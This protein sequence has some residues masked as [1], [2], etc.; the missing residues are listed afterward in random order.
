MASK[1][2]DALRGSIGFYATMAFCLLAIAVSGYFLLSDR[3]PRP[4]QEFYEDVPQTETT[5][6][7]VSPTGA[8][9]IPPV[10]EEPPAAEL[11]PEPEP[12]PESKPVSAP[13]PIPDTTPVEAE[14]PRLVVSPLKG[15]V[16]AAFSVDDLI[17]S[18]TMEDWRT[19]DGVDIAAA[20]G[21][22]VMAASAGT[23][24]AVFNDSMMGTTVVLEHS[25]GYQTTYANLQPVPT[26]KA[27]D[28]VSAGQIIGAVGTTAPAEHAQQ[29]H[30]H[31]A[32]TKDGA[33]VNPDE[34]LKN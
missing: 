16:L 33:V 31:F 7:E 4:P 28:S 12:I 5:M 26:V 13:T 21:T 34:F 17:Y 9:D 30:L 6:P 27:G 14:P 32:V 3:E 20:I 18:E 23:V 2:W 25:G 1:R 15:E 19:H 8:V 24:A 10:V 22:T 29:P 11:L